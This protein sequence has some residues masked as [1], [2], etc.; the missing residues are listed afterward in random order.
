[1]LVVNQADESLDEIGIPGRIVVT[2][3]RSSEI[4]VGGN[5]RPYA[6]PRMP[7]WYL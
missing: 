6:S 5:A 2:C 4:I 1:M 3:A 7:N